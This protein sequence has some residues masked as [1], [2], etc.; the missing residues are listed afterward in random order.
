MTTSSLITASTT[1]TTRSSSLLTIGLHILN[2]VPYEWTTRL[3]FVAFVIIMPIII[4]NLLVGLA[5]DDIKA[6]QEN[7]VLK[8]LALQ[9]LLKTL[10]TPLLQVELT[11][12]VEKLLPE[13]LRRRW[14]LR[15]QVR[16]LDRKFNLSFQS[17]LLMPNMN[18]NL[19]MS[20]LRDEASMK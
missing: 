20:F 9:V 10:I 17:K 13:C 5:V 2:Q 11:L 14:M 3:F 16:I 1:T 18:S 6:V 8:R 19:L 15:T 7:A 4:M 12:N